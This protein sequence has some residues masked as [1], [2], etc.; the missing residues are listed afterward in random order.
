[1]VA[2]T[3]WK[4]KLSKKKRRKKSNCSIR[5]RHHPR[6]KLNCIGSCFYANQVVLSFTLRLFFFLFLLLPP[7]FSS[8]VVSSKRVWTYIRIRSD[9]SWREGPLASPSPKLGQGSPSFYAAR[10]SLGNDE[11][12]SSKTSQRW[13]RKKEQ[14]KV[15]R[16]M[17][18]SSWCWFSFCFRQVSGSKPT[19]D[20]K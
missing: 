17:L 4:E 15:V 20:V 12:M 2:A 14:N 9:V 1:M 10:V 13:E 3:K 7:P 5:V 16:W 19:V 8:A 18:H 11:K 6:L